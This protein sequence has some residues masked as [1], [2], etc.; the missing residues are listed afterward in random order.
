MAI[1]LIKLAAGSTGL[2]SLRAWQEKVVKAR[3]RAGGEPY[4]VHVT[5]HRPKRAEELCNGGSLYWV[6][7]GLITA[8]QLVVDFEETRGQDGSRHCAIVLDPK[9]VETEL[10]PR[11]AFQGWRYLSVD[12]APADL[13][14]TPG[15]AALPDALRRQLLEV[16]AW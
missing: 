9:L 12:D 13:K 11:K 2:H 10:T 1:H 7:K 6:I 16:G 5:R 14:A 15:A 8:R 3:V 4:P